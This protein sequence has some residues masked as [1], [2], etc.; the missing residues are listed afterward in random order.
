MGS[1]IR[2][3]SRS[4]GNGF[5]PER[6]RQARAFRAFANSNRSISIGA[7]EG[8]FDGVHRGQKYA[9]AALGTSEARSWT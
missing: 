8:S 7:F 2:E 6:M 1:R 9:S 4:D 3:G 5:K